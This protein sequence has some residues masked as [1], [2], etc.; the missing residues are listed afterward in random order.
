[1]TFKFSSRSTGY[2]IGPLIHQYIETL[3]Y[4]TLVRVTL[5]YVTLVDVTLVYATL[6]YVTLVHVTLVLVTLVY[7]TLVFA[8][9]GEFGAC[10]ALI[11]RLRVLIHRLCHFKCKVGIVRERFSWGCRSSAAIDWDNVVSI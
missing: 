1:M 3:V 7:V 2:E 6:V 11:R 4:A 8:T 9:L 10:G 5:V